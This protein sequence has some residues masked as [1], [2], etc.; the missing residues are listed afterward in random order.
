MKE[1]WTYDRVK[2]T[3]K[4]GARWHFVTHETLGAEDY[5]EQPVECFFRDDARTFFGVLR[6]EHRKD[7]PYRD[8]ETMVEKIM[9]KPDFRKT[10]EDPATEDVWNRNWK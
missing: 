5:R 3:D 9:N 7:N 8:Y 6:F 4:R 1:M 10:L 2:R